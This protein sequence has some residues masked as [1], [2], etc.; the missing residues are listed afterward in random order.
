MKGRKGWGKEE[1]MKTRW[2]N[3]ASKEGREGGEEDGK[4]EGIKIR[5]EKRK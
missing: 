3:E 1:T 2:K 5:R 4:K